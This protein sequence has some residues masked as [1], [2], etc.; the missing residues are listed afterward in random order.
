MV[1]DPTISWQVEGG[2][3]EVITDFIFLSSRITVDNDCSHEIKTDLLLGRK[4]K[5]NLAY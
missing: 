4:A 5:T 3:V 1:S 2:N